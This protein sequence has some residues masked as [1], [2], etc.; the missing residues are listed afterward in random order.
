MTT[1]TGDKKAVVSFL[2][3]TSSTI[4]MGDSIGTV[5]DF[6]NPVSHSV[7]LNSAFSDALLEAPYS[8]YFYYKGSLT[9]P[10]CTEDV[11]WFVFEHVWSCAASDVTAM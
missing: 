1:S 10:D 2:F 5:L 11:D 3:A 4:V 7:D 8:R 6:T 9:F